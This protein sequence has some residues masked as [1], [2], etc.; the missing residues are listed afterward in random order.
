M[1][2]M[3]FWSRVINRNKINGRVVR[4]KGL[5]CS[6]PQGGAQLA[7]DESAASSQLNSLLGCADHPRTRVWLW[8]SRGPESPP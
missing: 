6:Y 2:K 4:G 7:G 5:G 8:C 1:V 3:I